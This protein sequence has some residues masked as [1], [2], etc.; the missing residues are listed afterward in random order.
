MVWE[1]AANDSYAIE[2]HKEVQRLAVWKA[3]DCPGKGGEIIEREVY[4]P[5]ILSLRQQET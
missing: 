4:T 5:E 3:D 1:D 2:S